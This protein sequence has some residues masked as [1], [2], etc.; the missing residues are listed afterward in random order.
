ME[1]VEGVAF[2]QRYNILRSQRFQIYSDEVARYPS[3]YFLTSFTFR[4]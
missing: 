2:H 4:G 1:K 3:K